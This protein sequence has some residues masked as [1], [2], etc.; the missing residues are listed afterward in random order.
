MKII[1]FN[2][3]MLCITSMV[4]GAIPIGNMNINVGPGLYNASGIVDSGR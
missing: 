4:R 2:S 1:A 3:S